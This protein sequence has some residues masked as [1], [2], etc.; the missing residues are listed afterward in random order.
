M[1]T[2]F[3]PSPTGPLHLGHAYSAFVGFDLAR[4]MGGKFLVRIED[5]DTTRCRPEWE[6]QIFDD[7]RWLGIEWEEPVL[8]QTERSSAYRDA[9]EVLWSI[10]LLYQCDCSRR[11][12]REAI[13]APQDGGHWPDGPDGPV[14]PGTCLKKHSRSGSMPD[15]VV[16]RLDVSESLKLV[17]QAID[18]EELG[19]GPRQ[20]KGTIAAKADHYM[21]QIGDVVLARRDM[22]GSY[23]LSVVLD[24]AFQAVT[25]VVRGQDLFD[26]TRIH[27]LLQAL[28]GQPTPAY[29]HHR[30]ITDG[31]GKRLAKR[32]DARAIATYRAEGATPADIRR[33]VG[34]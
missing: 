17:P 5:I 14:Y 10:G 29:L 16:L 31:A 21:G 1:I 13:R 7:L 20:E 32:D 22:A 25:H 9:L 24:D 15:D 12:V 8:R 27:V 30:L 34:L 18:F 6:K 11:D 28:L 26:A 23:H 19:C 33:M 3:A 4:K 2:R